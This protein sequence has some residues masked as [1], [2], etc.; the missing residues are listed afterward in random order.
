[1]AAGLRARWRRAFLLASVVAIV[2][3]IFGVL[4]T[5]Y[6]VQTT[7]TTANRLEIEESLVAELRSKMV[8]YMVRVIPIGNEVVPFARAQA[9]DVVRATF[10]RGIDLPHA[11]ALVPPLTRALAEWNGLVAAIPPV[12]PGASLEV[13]NV[14]GLALTIR[15]PKLLAA[16]AD[17]GVASRLTA[18]GDLEGDVRV[19]RVTYV[20]WAIIFLVIV[21][22]MVRLARRLNVE[23]LRPIEALRH[24]ANQLAQGVYTARVAVMRDDEIGQL[25]HSYNAMADAITGSHA[26]LTK[27]ANHDSLTGLA[28]RSHFCARV[29]QALALPQ[30][31]D[32]NQAILM[33]DLDDFK[34]VNDL[35]GHAAGDE[36]LSVAAARIAKAVRPGDLV[37]RLGGDE[38]A[39]FLD[40][41]PTAAAALSLATRVIA[42]LSEPVLIMDQSASVGASIGVAMRNGH[43]LYSEFLR[44]ADIAMYSAKA[45]G[46]SRVEL[47]DPAAHKLVFENQALRSDLREAAARGEFLLEFQPVIEL[48]TG[49][50]LGLEALIR[51]QHPTRGLMQPSQFIK[52]AEEN[53]SIVALGTWVLES[54]VQQ[55]AALQYRSNRPDLWTS[56]NVSVLQLETG[57]FANR[58]EAAL[59]DAGLSPA[60]L[61]VEVTESV[62]LDPGGRGANELAALRSLGVRV[63][64]DDFG[65]GYSSISYL[66]KFPVDI[67]KIDRSFVSVTEGDGEAGALLEAIVGLA[68][69]LHLDLIAEGIETAAD[70]ARLK[71][72]GCT[73]GQGFLLSRPIP[74]DQ[75]EQW[76]ADPRHR[77]SVG[78]SSQPSSLPVPRASDQTLPVITTGLQG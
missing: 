44:E 3:G 21:G 12:A 42:D 55:L 28:N 5:H 62:L 30:R 53:G 14:A 1:M 24:S 75:V 43:T 77:N 52:L 27:Q 38:F 18:R 29:E 39:I 72:L 40:G 10:Q 7:R 15:G 68:E 4:G 35:Q 36:I 76:L 11:K 63:A 71:I 73:M 26:D 8:A 48:M 67:L 9:E 47:Y 22:L 58:V 50:L 74:L 13:R 25:A 20:G 61:V 31:R 33:V 56:I 19:A 23:I 17:V 6:L 60:S 2:S 32:G 37:A 51:W 66:Q 70:L 16:L 69:R 59:L 54:T 49:R 45:M 65:T 78:P 64:L 34:D 41:I 46:K 57:E